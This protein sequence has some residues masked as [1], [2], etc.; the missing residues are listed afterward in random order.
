MNNYIPKFNE[1]ERLFEGNEAFRLGERYRFDNMDWK[2]D[3]AE[4]DELAKLHKDSTDAK[5]YVAKDKERDRTYRFKTWVENLDFNIQVDEEDYV[6][7]RSTYPLELRRNFDQDC[8]NI[9]G[10]KIKN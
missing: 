7:Y 1:F 5:V 6:I 2:F 10:F 8:E 4:K 9:L 3:Q